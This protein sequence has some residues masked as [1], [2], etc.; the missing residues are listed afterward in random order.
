MTHVATSL[1][2]DLVAGIVTAYRDGVPAEL[3]H[4]GR[5]GLLNALGLAI[6]ASGAEGISALI[7]NG[8]TTSA[9]LSCLVPGREQRVDPYTAS[10]ATAAAAHW[11]DFDDGH[12][13]LRVH[14]GPSALGAILVTGERVDARAE[15][16]LAAHALSGEVQFRLAAC[17]QPEHYEAGWH[18]TG[19][20]GAIASAIA[21]GCLLQLDNATIERAVSLAACQAGGIRQG[22]GTM[23]KPL[24]AGKAA[25]NGVLAVRL[26]VAGVDAATGVLEAPGGFLEAFSA[27]PDKSVVVAG[28]REHWHYLGNTYKP[29]PCGRVVHPIIDAALDLRDELGDVSDLDSAEIEGHP[30]VENLTGIAN[31]V[32]AHETKF[33]AAHGLA[34][35]LV[36]GQAST[37]EFT[38]QA[39]SDQALA[40][41]RDLTTLKIRDESGPGTD[42]VTIRL[43]T[44]TGRHLE[45]TVTA[46]RGTLARPLTFEDIQRKATHLIEP[47]LPGMGGPIADMVDRIGGTDSIR[48]LT[49]LVTPR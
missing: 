31:P 25:A 39:A 41:V 12:D 27:A 19:T 43:V 33:S 4:E 22:F 23:M 7:E 14:P 8:S 2:S 3:L 13:W 30:W 17:I 6:G 10:L 9:D 26:A 20:V 34:V 24:N 15:A 29:Y 49:D 42:T 21:V 1:T 35:A 48:R 45:Q 37:S 32:T 38:D 46:A 36:R 40:A 5:K 18:T 44:R 11:E 47:V 16:V 28:L